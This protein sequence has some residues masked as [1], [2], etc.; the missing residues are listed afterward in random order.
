MTIFEI[1]QEMNKTK[2]KIK[3]E[4]LIFLKGYYLSMYR[5]YMMKLY[6]DMYISDPTEFNEL[7]LRKNISDFG[8]S[9]LIG[10]SGSL[11]L[12][13]KQLEFAYLKAKSSNSPD[14]LKC[15]FLKYLMEAIKYWDCC[16]TLD[17]FYEEYNFRCCNIN[18]VKLHMGIFGAY[19]TARTG[20]AFNKVI[21]ECFTTFENDIKSIN[22]N[23]YIWCLAMEELGIPEVDWREDGLFDCALS[24]EDE[25]SCA[26]GIL[27]GKFRVTGG[28]YT[29]VLLNW[30]KTHPWGAERRMSYE[31]KGLF[32]YIQSS[33]AVEIGNY[34]GSVASSL[35]E[36]YEVVGMNDCDIYYKQPREECEYPFGLFQVI[37]TD[38]DCE[39]VI[40]DTEN[41]IYGVTGE[42]YS[43][44]R[45]DSDGI[46]YAGCPVRVEV[47]RGAILVY[48]REQLDVQ[49]DSWFKANDV[50][51]TFSEEEASH[52]PESPF[53]PGTLSDELYKGYVNSLKS[54]DN[55]IVPLRVSSLKQLEQAQKD[56]K[57]FVKGVMK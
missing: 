36:E 26:R 39:E 18:K 30:L 5:A 35:S 17:R 33:R 34:V 38:S 9:D 8:I 46:I 45:L 43:I 32:D 27:D 53:K 54:V 2:P 23:E 40:N 31:T 52:M 20:V 37:N 49:F 47:P 44:D 6:N 11:D 57:K 10:Y 42:L 19:V 29:D 50:E 16:V 13:Y 1:V 24:H 56:V 55:T 41:G 25:V 7:E 51:F 3:T 28:K 15:S 21:A 22:I 48:D 4:R 12:S 14:T